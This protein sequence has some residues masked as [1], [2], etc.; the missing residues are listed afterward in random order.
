MYL[1]QSDVINCDAPLIFVYQQNERQTWYNKSLSLLSTNCHVHKLYGTRAMSI[2]LWNYVICYGGK[3]QIPDK[4]NIIIN[5][6]TSIHINNLICMQKC[7]LLNTWRTPATPGTYF[8]ETRRL[9]NFPSDPPQFFKIDFFN[10]CLT[11]N[12]YLLG[13]NSQ[14]QVFY[15]GYDIDHY[16]NDWE[17]LNINH[18]LHSHLY[19]NVINWGFELE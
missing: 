4:Y 5:N 12:Y 9:T 13:K 17:N 1:G 8:M 3:W 14:I 18:F 10:S 16:D 6:K 11:I 15:G 19:C 2:P 7:K